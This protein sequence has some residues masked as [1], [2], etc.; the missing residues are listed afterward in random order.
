MSYQPGVD[1]PDA[2]P[3]RLR[4]VILFI[5]L[6][7]FASVAALAGGDILQAPFLLTTALLITS[8][9]L[10]GLLLGAFARPL[11]PMSGC[12]L[13]A[14]AWAVAFP[15]LAAFGALLVL[16]IWA[17]LFPPGPL[18]EAGA[19]ALAITLG[20]LGTGLIGAVALAPRHWCYPWG[21]RVVL[22][23]VVLFVGWVGSSW[24]QLSQPGRTPPSTLESAPEV[25]IIRARIDIQS[26]HVIDKP[27]LVEIV[28][29]PA[30]EYD[31]SQHFSAFKEIEGALVLKRVMAAEP[32]RRDMLDLGRP[33][34][35]AKVEI[36]ASTVITDVAR[37]LRTERV[38]DPQAGLDDTFSAFEQIYAARTVA[39]IRAGQRIVRAALD[40]ASLPPHPVTPLP[41]PFVALALAGLSLALLRAELRRP[42]V[43]RSAPAPAVA[44]ARPGVRRRLGWGV[45]LL[46]LGVML[47][48]GAFVAGTLVEVGRRPAVELFIL[49]TEVPL[50]DVV[51]ARIDL[52]ETTAITT[53]DVL[54]V[55]RVPAYQI[56]PKT[57]TQVEALQGAVVRRK[58]LAG[59]TLSQDDFFRPPPAA[60]RL[61]PDQ[62]WG[63]YGT[64]YVW[65]TELGGLVACIVLGTQ[66][67]RRSA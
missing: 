35:V 43:A 44:P 4:L 47:V 15:L 40:P 42:V 25:D 65:V 62:A 24:W 37:L 67:R 13:R 17:R 10:A 64:A 46:G 9:Q 52:V 18:G 30:S 60:A 31:P 29:I 28:R 27:A 32:L 66:L 6:L 8:L 22:V 26:M 3:S 34:L 59:T 48:T 45:A 7:A 20:A 21:V 54:E 41:I 12:A 33:V 39:P 49:P 36:A 5:L 58:I 1:L 56:D 38:F 55:V 53:P 11:R 51:R 16:A 14:V 23:A 2:A 19:T 63:R 50:V 57:I 61:T